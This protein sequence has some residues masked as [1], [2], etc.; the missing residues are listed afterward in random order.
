MVIPIYRHWDLAERCL[1][2]VAFSAYGNHQVI[3]VDHGP[4]EESGTALRERFA[5]V[6]WIRGDSS[7]WWAGATNAGTR[8]ALAEG[9]AYVMW[10]NGDCC[11]HPSTLT[12]LVRH[13]QQA[14]EAIVAPVQKDACDGHIVSFDAGYCFTLG[15]VTRARRPRPSVSVLRQVRLIAGGRGVLIPAS[16]IKR[17]GLLDEA[18]LPHYYADHDFYLRCR[19]R[20]VR[21]YVASDAAVLVDPTTTTTADNPGSLTL[22]EFRATLHDP[23]SH[24]NIAY[25]N[26]FFRKHYPFTPLYR[27]GTWLNIARYVIVYLLR[28][29][30]WRAR[31]PGPQAG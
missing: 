20:G 12:T 26:A 17:I 27:L 13:L 28:R 5:E 4:E 9:V 24:R 21:L 30:A 11:L 23:R 7:Q 14:G 6:K 25:L 10:L 29:V 22:S 8:A 19:A 31:Y 1:T 3:V 16:V 2:S 18:Q 15:F